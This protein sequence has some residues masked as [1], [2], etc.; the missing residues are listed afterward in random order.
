MKI[1]GYKTYIKLLIFLIIIGMFL[2]VL[3]L[4]GGI[5]FIR[6]YLLL[7]MLN[8][9]WFITLN[10]HKIRF[11]TW[12]VILIFLLIVS[13][14]KGLIFNNFSD[15]TFIDIY[16]PLSFIIIFHLFSKVQVDRVGLALGLRKVNNVLFKTSIIFGAAS[17]LLVYTLGG[18]AGVRLPIALSIAYFATH[19]KKEK[20]FI[21]LIAILLSGKRAILAAIVPVLLIGFKFKITIKKIGV[22]VMTC[23]LVYIIAAVNWETMKQTAVLSKFTYTVESLSEY[24]ETKD[25]NTLNIMSGRRLQEVM[26]GLH[27]FSATDYLFGKGTSYTFDD[28]SIDRTKIDRE[29]VANIHFSPASLTASY[30]LV[31]M[32]IFYAVFVRYIRKG[33]KFAKISQSK[34]LFTLSLF[35]T[36]IFIESFFAY[37]LFV[38]PLFPIAMGLIVNE[39]NYI[40]ISKWST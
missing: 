21:A 35:C 8:N 40:K 13:F 29:D 23:L 25:L 14:C 39:V 6:E 22:L 24:W 32:L 28:Y 10:L 5:N 7:V 12:S 9:I 37:V 33:F 3:R 11:E 4:Y 20:I 18:Y 38:I 34:T 16:K 19:L 26:S 30:G 1:F 15:R 31:F 17:F 27:E 2:S 36:A